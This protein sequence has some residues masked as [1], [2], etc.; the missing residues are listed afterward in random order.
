MCCMCYDIVETRD[1]GCC[2]IATISAYSKSI[3]MSLSSTTIK[4]TE[5]ILRQQMIL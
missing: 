4:H 1:R 2:V 3:S 5:D